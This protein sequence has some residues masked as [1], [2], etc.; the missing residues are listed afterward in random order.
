M[1]VPIAI[2]ALRQRTEHDT[3]GDPSKEL[4]LG[5]AEHLIIQS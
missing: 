5:S 1:Q 4:D 2:G 3:I